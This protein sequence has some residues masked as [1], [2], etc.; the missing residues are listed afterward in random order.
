M[1]WWVFKPRGNETKVGTIMKIDTE[2]I[3]KNMIV[4]KEYKMTTRRRE[5]SM[6]HQEAVILNRE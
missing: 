3:K 6:F 2:T 4:T 1:Y 5:T